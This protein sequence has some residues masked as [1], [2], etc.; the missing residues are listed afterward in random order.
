M[1]PVY[2]QVATTLF[3][4]IGAG[5]IA[6][7]GVRTQRTIARQRAT[8]DHFAR[9]EADKD[10]I[11]ARAVFIRL[12]REGS[13]APW[14]AADKEPSDEAQKIGLVL[15]DYELIALGISV[16]IIDEPLCRRY[17]RATMM[18]YWH[19]A[20]PFV[21]ALRARTKSRNIYRGFERL[22]SRL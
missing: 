15:N 9:S 21:R 18:A 11:A 16:G 20:R 14:A 5:I 13:L 22:V 12:A 1:E 17:N 7:W 8:I 6:V 3:I 2:L 19:H 10:L 4:G